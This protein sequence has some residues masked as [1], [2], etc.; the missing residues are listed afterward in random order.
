MIHRVRAER[1]KRAMEQA[2]HEA[3][4]GDDGE[5]CPL[6]HEEMVRLVNEERQRRATERA[7]EE[8]EGP[9]RDELLVCACVDCA[10]VVV[11]IRPGCARA[12]GELCGQRCYTHE[13]IYCACECDSQVKR[14]LS[15]SEYVEWQHNAAGGGQGNA[16]H[17]RQVDDSD[18]GGAAMVEETDDDSDDL[19][20]HLSEADDEDPFSEDDDED[21]F[22]VYSYSQPMHW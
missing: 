13:H 15:T 22:S 7:R 21:Q 20:T 19:S 4:A 3:P 14:P 11:F 10:A 1:L 16:H 8:E 17:H 6:S 12:T 9:S 5:G 18:L 2:G